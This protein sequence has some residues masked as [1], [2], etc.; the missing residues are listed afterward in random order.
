MLHE[1]PRRCWSRGRRA[2]IPG[3]HVRSSSASTARHNHSKR[4]STATALAE[5]FG[6]DLRSLAA[7]GG[8]PLDID[9]L[10]HID[11]LEWDRR[12]PV[13]AFVAASKNA[14]LV[15][16]GGRG[17]SGVRALGSVSERVA[18]PIART[19]RCSSCGP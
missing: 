6:A 12:Q 8:Q 7:E 2:T 19:A 5:R 9:G 14:D 10:G 16:V 1:A 18:S 13:S 15:I 3:S 11:E 17:L 4:P